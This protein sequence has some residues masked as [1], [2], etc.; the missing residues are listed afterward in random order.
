MLNGV[1]AVASRPSDVEKLD[2]PAIATPTREMRSDSA[3]AAVAAP[4]EREP[5]SES[6]DD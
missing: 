4:S 5:Y 3:A 1:G 2:T 6:V